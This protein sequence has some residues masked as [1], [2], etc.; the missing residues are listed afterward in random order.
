MALNTLT[1][2]TAAQI[3]LNCMDLT[4]LND[5]DTPEKIIQLS[6]QA[7]QSVGHVAAICIYPQFIP[8]AKASLDRSI[9][10]A[11]VTNF[12]SGGDDVALALSQTHEA[13][14]LGA[15][16]V[17]VVFPY[18]ALLHGDEEVGF[19]L[20]SACKQACGDTVCLKVIIESGELKQPELIKRASEIA[21]SAGADFIKT[22][23]G[24]VPV[25]ATLE[26]AEIMLNAIKASGKMVGFKAA[27]GVRTVEDAQKYI[28]LAAA[29]MGEAWVTPMHFRFGASGLLADV[30]K[31]LNINNSLPSQQAGY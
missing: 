2:L 8:V 14:R 16:E 17:D 19:N 3:A 12:P 1:Q 21:I 25:N 4:S 30:L 28:E 22:S 9:R 23:T 15:D 20:V 31:V 10:I 26:A 24:K 7:N 27:G 5:D 11:T 29:I 18:L 13:V 6:Q